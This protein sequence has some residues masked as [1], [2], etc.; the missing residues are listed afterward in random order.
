MSPARYLNGRVRSTIVARRNIH[1]GCIVSTHSVAAAAVHDA[2]CS[3]PPRARLSTAAG[4]K[5]LCAEHI[6]VVSFADF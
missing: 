6:P 3:H 1:A 2:E 4:L 5:G